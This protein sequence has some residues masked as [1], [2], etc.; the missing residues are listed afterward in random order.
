MQTYVPS[1]AAQRISAAL[2]EP[3][4]LGQATK[5]VVLTCKDCC[6]AVPLVNVQVKHEHLT[7]ACTIMTAPQFKRDRSNT[8]CGHGMWC[9]ECWG[10][11]MRGPRATTAVGVA[12]QAGVQA[13]LTA[14]E[15]INRHPAKTWELG[16]TPEDSAPYLHPS[17]PPLLRQPGR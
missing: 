15:Q 1:A 13:R 5:S 9:W 2:L 8:L 14:A 10:S 3:L 16:T 11:A 4:G 6:A 12:A 7:D 17:G